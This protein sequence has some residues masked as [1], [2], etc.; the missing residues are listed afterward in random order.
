VVQVFIVGPAPV[1]D[2]L[3]DLT[4]LFAL[5]AM[6]CAFVLVSRLRALSRVVGISS[7]IALHRGMGILAAGSVLLHIGAVIAA[8]PNNLLLLSWVYAPPRARAATGAT[9]A[10]A[11]VVA[12][13]IYRSKARKDY[14]LWRWA[15][16]V[17]GVAA[18]A[19]GGLHVWLIGKLVQDSVMGPVLAALG[20]IFAA[21]LVYRFRGARQR[22]TPHVVREI[23]LE[24][25]SVCTVVLD[26][27]GAPLKFAPG[28]FAWVSLSP[29][30]GVDD[31]PF[32]IASSP[33]DDS[34]QFTI[35]STGD[36]GTVL[37]ELE[38]GTPV[39]VDGPYGS[40]SVDLLPQPG[41]G[42][43]MFAAGV[44]ITPMLSQL[45]TLAARR[46]PRPLLLVRGARTLDDLLFREELA[47]LA[48]PQILPGLTVV[49]VMRD[50]PP[51][52]D[53]LTGEVDLSVL[54][55]LL[56]PPGQRAALDYFICGPP[57]F[58][59]MVANSLIE[60]EV[61]NDR[62]HAERF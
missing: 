33:V 35:R 30:G 1:W 40:C 48:R 24:S 13:G 23:R 42:A 9:L 11:G 19:L 50:P 61:P 32:T 31:H 27:V 18:V 58:V 56:P 5:S 25:D 41:A 20:L 29:N 47:A 51:G 10:L 62:V 17:L 26:P 12:L 3:V 22:S 45:R 28:Q 59:E 46:D 54:E 16:L 8:D 49:E 4:G 43:A 21:A 36:F 53:G 37:R 57:S 60:L 7:M 55:Y 6:I 44:G 52:W 15:H 38:P 2:Q 14:E 39:W 34:C